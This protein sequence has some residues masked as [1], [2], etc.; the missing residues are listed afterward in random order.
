M[1]TICI[2]EGNTRA[3]VGMFAGHNMV[4]YAAFQE[5]W[6]EDLKQFIGTT[7]IDNVIVTS[8]KEDYTRLEETLQGYNTKIIKSVSDIPLEI[9]YDTP[10]TL[11]KDRVLSAYA[12]SQ[13]F[14]GQNAAIFDIGT[15]MTSDFLYLG[16]KFM[17]GNISPGLH[18]RLKAMHE[19]TAKL[20]WV[21]PTS[22]NHYIGKSTEKA[23][24]NGGFYGM[25]YEIEGFIIS[26][27]KNYNPVRVMLTGGSAHFFAERLERKIYIDH[28]LNIKG[29]HY[30]SKYYG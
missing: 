12:A 14:P 15:C 25:L 21:E 23:L 4:K 10:H 7:T 16:R 11:G 24:Q 20:P 1:T 9:E 5:D 29:L 17:G 13:L 28:F 3:K 30:L 18:M 27:R 6:S 8:T 19:Y 22:E 26:L 2:D